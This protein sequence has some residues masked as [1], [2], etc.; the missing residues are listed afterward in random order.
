VG[1]EFPKLAPLEF[2]FAGGSRNTEFK[3]MIEIR[4][5]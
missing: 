4:K 1:K 2:L 5:I 3:G